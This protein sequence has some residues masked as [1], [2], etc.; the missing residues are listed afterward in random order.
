VATRYADIGACS[1]AIGPSRAARTS[2]PSIRSR[3][4]MP[5]RRNRRA[6]LIP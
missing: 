2:T 3:G 5:R 4:S 6:P 1:G